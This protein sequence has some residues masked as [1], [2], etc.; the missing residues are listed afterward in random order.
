MIRLDGLSTI[1]LLNTKPGV[2]QHTLKIGIFDT[3]EVPG[4]WSFEKF[5]D[6]MR[7]SHQAWPI[8]R[9]KIMHVPFGLHHPV[10]VDDP[11][12]SLDYHMRYV[13]CPPPADNR[14]LCALISQIYAYPLDPSKPLWLTWVIDGLADGQV[15]LVTL[16]HHSYVDGTGASRMMES[17]LTPEPRDIVPGKTE[18]HPE[19]TPTKLRLIVDALRDIPLSLIRG[20]PKLVKARRKVRAVQKQ[21][22][23]VGGPESEFLNPFRDCRDSPFNIELSAGRTFVFET[24]SFEGFRS[25]AKQFDVTVNDLFLAIIADVFR[26]FMQRCG[27]DPDEGPLL[28]A[29]PFQRRP[30]VELD[31]MIGNKTSVNW[32]WLPTHL[33]DYVERLTFAHKHALIMKDHFETME[34]ADT[35]SLMEIVPLPV[36]TLMDKRAKDDPHHFGTSANALLSNV[37]G[38]T[39][40][41]H[42]GR[43]K[44]TNWI[45]MGQITQGMGV[46]C[47]VW[48]YAGKFNLCFL[49]DKKLQTDGWD[50]VEHF[51]ETLALYEKL[52]Q[53]SARLVTSA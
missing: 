7:D 32:L 40:P 3:S 50:L 2:Y 30:P 34:G 24:L 46:N 31:D 14:A 12:F 47:T 20:V 22:V 43:M 53:E 52:S 5:K 33:T 17:Y 25:V 51:K 21:Y 38:P 39:K 16:L 27:Y 6:S 19:E 45:S 48:S 44:M 26:R 35:S 10:W 41:L 9:C 4:G 8:F 13:S 11:D 36:L 23:D 42:W 18:W 15:A 49:I 37:K 1:Q 28:G 29:I